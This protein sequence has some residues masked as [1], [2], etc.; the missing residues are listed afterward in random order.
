MSLRTV[1]TV[2]G[3]GSPALDAGLIGS[4]I[5]TSRAEPLRV[6]RS[7]S[8]L[9]VAGRTSGTGVLSVDR[10]MPSAG[11]VDADALRRVLADLREARPVYL[12]EAAA[13][14]ARSLVTLRRV[15]VR[16]VRGAGLV[17]DGR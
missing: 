16:D 13:A 7:A 3:A 5:A 4:L 15:S 11:P 9:N 1:G 10:R 8:L 2:G 12:P 6:G 14:G 17:I